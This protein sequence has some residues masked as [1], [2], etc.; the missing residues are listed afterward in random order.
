MK[1]EAE[2][3]LNDLAKA[4]ISAIGGCTG[5]GNTSHDNQ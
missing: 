2:Y 4:T 1:A 3:L 5:Q